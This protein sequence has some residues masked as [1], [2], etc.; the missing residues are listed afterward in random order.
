MHEARYIVS[1]VMSISAFP[2]R[3]I[4]SE[5]G[6]GYLMSKGNGGEGFWIL[7]LPDSLLKNVEEYEIDD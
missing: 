7:P 4:L 6:G 2:R 3:T 1:M 5:S